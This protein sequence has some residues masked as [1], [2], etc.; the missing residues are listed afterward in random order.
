MLYSTTSAQANMENS[1]GNLLCTQC[2][3]ELVLLPLMP[4]LPFAAFAAKEQS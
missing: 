2:N 4:F 1:L 3:R